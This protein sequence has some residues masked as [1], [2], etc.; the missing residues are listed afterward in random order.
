[1]GSSLFSVELELGQAEL[2]R[3]Q[4]EHGDEMRS[5]TT[6]PT[7]LMWRKGGCQPALWA[8]NPREVLRERYGLYRLP[9]RAAWTQA[10]T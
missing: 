3:H 10:R 8:M 2:A 9:T 7:L 4:I 5:P 6:S 1:M